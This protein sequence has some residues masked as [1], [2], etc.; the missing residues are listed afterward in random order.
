MLVLFLF[1]GDELSGHLT[2][3]GCGD[4]P[5]KRRRDGFVRVNS[6]KRIIDWFNTSTGIPLWLAIFFES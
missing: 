6:L 5:Y 2:G 3:F 4:G 1:D